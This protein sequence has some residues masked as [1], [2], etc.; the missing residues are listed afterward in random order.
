MRHVSMMSIENAWKLVQINGN[1]FNGHQWKAKT[2]RITFRHHV[3]ISK[4]APRKDPKVQH[5][6]LVR[7]FNGK[8]G[9]Q[10]RGGV[11]S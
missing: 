4:T 6:T 9:A 5:V 3:L 8:S 11:D 7:D 10:S 2:K 1:G